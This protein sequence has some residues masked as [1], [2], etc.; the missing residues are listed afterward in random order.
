MLALPA[1]AEESL[2]EVAKWRLRELHAHCTQCVPSGQ[3]RILLLDCVAMWTHRWGAL[4]VGAEVLRI[5][6]E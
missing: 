2:L 1:R 6:R 5:T 3:C 4:S